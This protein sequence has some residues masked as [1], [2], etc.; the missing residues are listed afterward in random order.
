MGLGYY[1]SRWFKLGSAQTT[2]ITIEV[3][4][5]NST[6]SMFMALSLLA[7]YKMSFTPAIYTLIMLFTAGVLV[8]VLRS[9]FNGSSK[10]AQS[11]VEGEV[12]GAMTSDVI[13]DTSNTIEK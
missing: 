8:R 9:K 5:Q 2:S 6:L 12:N 7:N 3:G 4:L 11:D 13:C 10:R 1:S